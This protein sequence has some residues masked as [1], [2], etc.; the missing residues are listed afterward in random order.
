MSDLRRAAD[1][2]LAE[3]AAMLGD[4]AVAVVIADE[5]G[6]IDQIEASNPE[7]L[8]VLTR[9]RAGGGSADGWVYVV[10]EPGAVGL[11]A[12][13]AASFAQLVVEVAERTQELIMES[14]KFFGTEFPPCPEHQG[15]PL[16]PSARDEPAWACI[17]GGMTTVPI[18]SLSA[19]V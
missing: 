15:T 16:W 8:E 9:P 12:Y 4:N 10:G 2:V 6:D 3:V 19:T 7:M 1:L 5:P 17:D 13:G 18:G 11:D 14:R